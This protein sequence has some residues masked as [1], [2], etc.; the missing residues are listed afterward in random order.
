MPL[1]HEVWPGAVAIVHDLGRG[2][3]LDT[4][5]RVV[6]AHAGACRWRVELGDQVLHDRVWREAQIAVGEAFGDIQH[7]ARLGCELRSD[8]ASKGR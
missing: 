7:R 6:P 5:G 8:P 4:E 3:P 2:G 1:G